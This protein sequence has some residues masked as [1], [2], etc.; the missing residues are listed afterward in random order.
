V[1]VRN[2]AFEK[3]V[4]ARFTTD[5]WTTVSESLARYMGPAPPA[6]GQGGSDSDGSGSSTWD[7]FVFSISLELCARPPGAAPRTLLLAVRFTA[8]GV[9][10]WWDN[11]GGEDFCV[12]LAAKKAAVAAAGE[13]KPAAR[14]GAVFGGGSDAP[15]A[16]FF[17]RR[18]SQTP[19][20]S[21][22]GQASLVACARPLLTP[23]TVPAASAVTSRCLR[24]A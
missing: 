2:L 23:Y 15:P 3:R 22:G 10:E 20:R 14:T 9:G 7:R 11:N 17:P 5:G 13:S 12:V 8:P 19:S 4:A 6:P 18:R 1:R 24:V 21:D 16:E